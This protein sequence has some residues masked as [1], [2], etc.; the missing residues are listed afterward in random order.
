[1][2]AKIEFIAS[3][4][5]TSPQ[6]F[7]AGATY[8]GINKKAKYGLD[9]GILFSEVPGVATAL[10][11]TNRIK[12]AP[13][14][15]CQQRLKAGRALAVVVNSGCA[16]ACTGEQ[17]LADAAEMAELAA[18][19][20]GISPEDVLVASTGVI[21]LP[22]PMELI[23]AGIDQIV[24]SRDGGH[25]LARA[26]MTTDTFPK[27]AAVAAR[28]DDSKF[29]IGGVAK[30]SGMIHPNLATLLCLLATDAAVDIDFLK[31]TLREAVALSFNMISIDGDTSP[32]DMVLIMANG[33]AGNEVI[34]S[35]SEQASTFHQALAQICIYLAKCIARDGEGAS[36]L[37]EVTVGGAPSV[38]EARLVARTVVSSPLVKAAIHGSDPNW[39]RI[40][41]AVG[42]SG[43]EVVE[44][45][46][47][48]YIGNICL[49]RCG[50]QLLFDKEEVVAILRSPE[51]PI[52]LQL[53]LGTATA[54][55]W[56][57]DLSEEYV[58]INSQYTT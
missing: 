20:I 4:S 8:A 47:D 38:A 36:K 41:A 22:L 2:E 53:N 48:L 27:E 50:H 12:A 1:M 19:G 26:M 5:V 44:S 7:H 24:L 25:E 51:V 18:G 58:S 16:N 52:R 34:S 56:G 3:G 39:G 13:V 14:V 6:G 57:C 37:I 49:A 42:R 32:N 28:V 31:F 45:K 9:L 46:I 43:V 55:A 11:T 54:T 35:D 15:L 21:G 33:L 10:F 17:G 23:R 40:M 30:G 29:I